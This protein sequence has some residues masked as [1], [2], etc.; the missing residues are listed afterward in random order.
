MK[1]ILSFVGGM[2]LAMII[3]MGIPMSIIGIGVTLIVSYGIC[4]SLILTLLCAF[5]LM[6]LSLLGIVAGIEL[7]ERITL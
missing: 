3:I 1:N 7:F 6:F 5:G 4:K 2:F